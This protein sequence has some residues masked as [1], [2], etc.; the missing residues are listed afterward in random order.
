MF[1][2]SLLSQC[3]GLLFSLIF[4]L[5]LFLSI[6]AYT[7]MSPSPSIRRKGDKI[8]LEIEELDDTSKE[9]SITGT[10]LSVGDCKALA[11]SIKKGNLE[12][13]SLID[14]FADRSPKEIRE[15]LNIILRALL[16]CSGLHIV[17]ISNNALGDVDIRPLENF[18]S[19]HVPLEHLTLTNNGIGPG[20]VARIALAVIKLAEA[21]KKA[22][23]RN[24]V[25]TVIYGNDLPE[26]E[27][28]ESAST[29]NIIATRV[30]LYRYVQPAEETTADGRVFL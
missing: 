15:S 27:A 29:Q 11:K 21:K 9:V 2:V 5:L 24:N 14:V 22:S 4:H 16:T 6:H 26:E 7:I 17:N 10:S 18:V 19:R 3:N 25:L 1:R 12:A 20:A 30:D 8:D 23:R 13:I 28:M